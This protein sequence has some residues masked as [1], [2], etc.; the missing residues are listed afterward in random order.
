MRNALGAAT[1]PIVKSSNILEMSD[2]KSHLAAKIVESGG[3][4][5]VKSALNPILWLCGIITVPSI[6]TLGICGTSHWWLILLAFTP[7]F[8]AVFGFIYLLMVDRDKLQSEDY[9]IRKRSLEM[10]EQ[11]GDLGPSLAVDIV[12]IANPEPRAIGE[13]REVGQ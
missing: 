3:R 2:E 9:Q 13:G 1:S 5:T 8:A 11:K 6:V 4:L 12:T 10:I 7:V